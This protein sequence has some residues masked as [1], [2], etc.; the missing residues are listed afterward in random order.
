MLVW[1]APVDTVSHGKWKY[2]G[3]RNILYFLFGNRLWCT[4]L[5]RKYL[6][7]KLIKVDVFKIKIRLDTF[8]SPTSISGRREYL[9]WKVLGALSRFCWWEKYA[10]QNVFI[11]Q[12]SLWALAAPQIPTSLCEGP[13]FYFSIFT[14]MQ[15]VKVFHSI[16]FHFL[17]S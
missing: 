4:P 2:G 17:F 1:R 5:V 6:S 12:F 16:P 10:S 3:K 11:S 13:I 14:F 7:E 9:E 8:I 15:G